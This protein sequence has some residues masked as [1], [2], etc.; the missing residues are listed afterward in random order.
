MACPDHP[1]AR[2][3]SQINYEFLDPKLA[4]GADQSD[5]FSNSFP[6]F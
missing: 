5:P 4:L 6:Y 1:C 2:T 3:A